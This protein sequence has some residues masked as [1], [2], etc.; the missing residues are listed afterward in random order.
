MSK[1]IP[2]LPMIFAPRQNS[3]LG[4]ANL[5]P[6]T[7]R[8]ATLILNFCCNDVRKICALYRKYYMRTSYYIYIDNWNFNAV[9]QRG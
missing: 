7:A 8:K 2:T 9:E 6:S 5:V 1:I 4:S 3:N